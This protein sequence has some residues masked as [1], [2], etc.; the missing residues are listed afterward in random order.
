M[1]QRLHLGSMVKQNIFT[2]VVKWTMG[3]E[4]EVL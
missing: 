2:M 4:Y 1:N 3:G